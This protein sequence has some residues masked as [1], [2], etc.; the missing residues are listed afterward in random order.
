MASEVIGSAV[1]EVTA[2]AS[3]L[4]AG[5]A[6]ATQA[7][8][9]FEA[10]AAGSGARAGAAMS[11][12]NK[13]ASITS[14]QLTREQERL[15][16]SINNY[17]STLG[18]S[19]GEVLEYRASQAGIA[20]QVQAQIAAIRAQEAALASSGKALN[21][22]GVSAGQTAAALRQVPAQ[23]SDIVVSLQGG[24]APLTV[25][26]QQGSQLKDSF[27]GVVPAAKAL[28]G[29]LLGLV[30]PY[31]VVAAAVATLGVAY[32]QGSKESTEYGKALILTGNY[33]GQTIGQ[34]QDTAAALTT[35]GGTQ[36]K[37]SQALAALAS[38]GKIGSG[39]L[40]ELAGSAVEME[41]VLG[42]SIEN[43]VQQFVKLADEPTKASAKLNESLHYLSQTTYER[44]RA[45]EEQGQKEQAAALAQIT[46][47]NALKQRA[48]EV[49][50][51]L[52]TIERAW[53]D[54]RSAAAR[55]WDAILGVGRT[56]TLQTQLDDV[57]KKLADARQAA[58]GNS[59]M[60]S[61]YAPQIDRLVAQQAAL[62][63]TQRIAR[64]SAETTAQRARD[65]QAAIDATDSISKWQEKAKGVDAV[66][67]ELKKYRAELEAVRKVNP[68]SDRL[69]PE[70]VRAGE[71]QIRKDFAAPKSAAPRAFQDDAATK[72]LQSL[73]E[74]EASLQA[75]LGSTDKLTAS[76]KELAKFAQQIADIKEKR[77]LTAEQKSLLASQDA[78]TAQLQKNVA[79]EAEVKAQQDK[80]K[81]LEKQVE[82][83]K[84]FTERA[85]QIQDQ[86]ANSQ[87]SRRE[88]YDR[89]LGAFGRS[90]QERQRLE[91]Q[92]QLYRENERLQA[93]LTKAM[94]KELP[95]SDQYITEMTKIKG[96]LDQSLAD[97]N[98]YYAAL[99]AAQGN[100][101]NGATRA[102]GTYIE[103]VDNAS[104]RTESLVSNT[105]D[106]F[107]DA[108]TSAL[109]GE[110]G[111][112]KNIGKQIQEQILKGIVQQQITKPLAQWLQRSL[113][114]PESLIGK[115]LGGLMSN[116]G[117]GENWLSGLFGVGTSGSSGT[118]MERGA[119]VANPLYVRSADPVSG[120][121]SGSSSSSGGSSWLD[122]A[123]RIGSSLYGGFGNSTAT[124]MAN[125]SGT[126]LDGLFNYTNN[127]AGRANGGWVGAR[128][129]A[130]VAENAPELIT[131]GNKTMLATGNQSAQVTPLQ[132]GG[133]GFNYSPTFILDQPTSRKTQ[134]QVSSKALMGAQRALARTS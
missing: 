79:V 50:N 52:G 102:L 16:A 91:D 66:T 11:K 25:L 83:Q 44:I 76:E 112:L 34:L 33:A 4:S 2:D 40:R 45:L 105:L 42:T 7:V 93:Q 67:R 47:S 51:N 108:L 86:I 113:Q 70:A 101:V 13:D 24:Q 94:P 125:A 8:K 124:A 121:T 104:R 78:I 68:N 23:L 18:K 19:R 90:D 115:G 59:V 123:F 30:N 72:Y 99:Q 15:I 134:E 110:S 119:S 77:T 21:R 71:E 111:G 57:S 122:T 41:R 54:V 130:E 107:D 6:Q 133:G 36:A 109:M 5:I 10:A 32:A 43:S 126:G 120:F 64:R 118:G 132:R 58:S 85:A 98:D 35:L 87:Q 129:L 22:Y 28:G 9:G 127:F 131:V 97:H 53:F 89:T 74:T 100:W 60:S 3:G 26:L 46:L 81:E 39:V 14:A 84:R 103:E 114:D 55:G 69:K 116:K 31:T 63:E 75:Q 117:T 27:G 92:Q 82:A 17:G 61:L 20:D 49:K 62:Q 48:D 128:G 56:A 65:E 38:S 29:A 73:R 12:A 88:G 1:V 95:G 96:A 80:T 37:A 106:S